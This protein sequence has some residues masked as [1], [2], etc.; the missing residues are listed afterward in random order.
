[1]AGREAAQHRP[2]KSH[3]WLLG[4]LLGGGQRRLVPI[5]TAGAEAKKSSTSRHQ[6]SAGDLEAPPKQGAERQKP[7]LEALSYS[8]TFPP[9]P[10][11]A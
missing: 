10:P 11:A 1:M 5:H 7:K 6:I 2:G 3:H 4:P 8:G 9:P